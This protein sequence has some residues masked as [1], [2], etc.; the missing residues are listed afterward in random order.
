[1]TNLNNNK[2]PEGFVYVSELIPT[3]QESIVYAGVNN[4]LGQPVDGY[5][6]A[7]AILTHSAAMALKSAQEYLLKAGF[8]LKIFD[9]YRPKRAVKHFLRWV[10]E[11]DIVACKQRFYP[12]FT[13]A[14]LFQKGYLATYSSHSRG[15]TVDLTIVSLA[16]GIELDMGTEFDFF[17]EASWSNYQQLSKKQLDNRQYLHSVMLEAGFQPFELEWW[18][19]TLGNEPYPSQYFDFIVK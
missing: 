4:F 7:K 16:T 19:F 11:P 2:L 5:I 15:S 8:S 13:K 12:D 1:M 18:H 17:G 9:A 10:D 6:S 14:E 3:I